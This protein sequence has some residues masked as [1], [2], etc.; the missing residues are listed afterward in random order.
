[1]KKNFK[2]SA[3]LILTMMLAFSMLIGTSSVFAGG[4]MII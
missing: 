3:I 2:K 4:A 1:M